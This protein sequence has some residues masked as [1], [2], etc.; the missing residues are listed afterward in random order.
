M[1]SSPESSPKDSSPIVASFEVVDTAYHVS[2]L[3]NTNLSKWME[4]L[5][6]EK[7]LCPLSQLTIP[8]SHNSCGFWFDTSLEIAPG[9]PK[10]VQ[11]LAN[12]LGNTTKTV[13]KNW[14]L[15]Q[16]YDIKEQL[17]SGIRY[18]DFR[19]AFRK[20]S[21]EFRFVHGLY[22]HPVEGILED[23]KSFLLLNPKEVV[24]LDFNHLYG[25]EIEEHLRFSTLLMASFS[26]MFH[27]PKKDKSFASL[28]ELW[29]AGE[30]VIVFYPNSSV[31]ELF[32]SFFGSDALCSPWPN[33]DK[34]EKLLEHISAH[35][36]ASKTRGQFHVTQAVLTP[37][38]SKVITHFSGSL[39]SV[40]TS[41][42]NEAI[43][44]LLK[45]SLGDKSFSFNIILVDHVE[46]DDLI[47]TIIGFN[48]IY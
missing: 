38:T 37:Q 40:L 7:Q 48:Y 35:G 11:T 20:E 5:P 15:T 32:P 14:S 8:G 19:V 36:L 44:S 9:Q 41:E 23:I 22:G 24:I 6:N 21:D 39:K 16:S 17:G 33:T 45:S 43:V 30:Q 3:L 31:L 25:M 27:S 10:A 2:D 12:Y 47:S 1:E 46:C 26:D 13:M 34:K 42:G 28:Q 29:L 4:N 18:F